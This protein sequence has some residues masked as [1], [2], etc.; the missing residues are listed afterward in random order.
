MLDHPL[1]RN[2]SKISALHGL[3]IT[4]VRGA[5]LAHDAAGLEQVGAVGDLEGL[6]G[7]LFDHEDADAGVAHLF[8]HAA[9]RALLEWAGS[10]LGDRALALTWQYR[11]RSPGSRPRVVRAGSVLRDNPFVLDVFLARL[12]SSAEDIGFIPA[13][14]PP[15]R[16]AARSRRLLDPTGCLL[17]V[18]S[19]ASREW[20]PC[21]HRQVGFSSSFPVALLPM[22]MPYPASPRAQ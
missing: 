21:Q 8:E 9:E 3:V 4:Q 18:C 7:A 16:G 6:T 5:A 15:F 20:R 19:S 1:L 2:H 17:Q 22:P 14:F 13:M 12:G 10:Q 11:S